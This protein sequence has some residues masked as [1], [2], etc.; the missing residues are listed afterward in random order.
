[1]KTVE[2]IIREVLDL[3]SDVEVTDAFNADDEPAW[4]SL[5]QLTI[6]DNLEEEYNVDFTVEDALEMYSVG[7]IKKVLK[8]KG[9]L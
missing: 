2:D 8:R 3:G 5:V 7:D 1:M 9:V 4:D 6:I